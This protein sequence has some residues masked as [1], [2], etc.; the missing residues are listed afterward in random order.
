MNKAVP[1]LLAI[2]CLISALDLLWD[3]VWPDAEKSE[4]RKQELRGM[5]SDVQIGT[6]VFLVLWVLGIVSN[7]EK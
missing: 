6:G 4:E 2:T 7:T 5:K 1:S 3:W